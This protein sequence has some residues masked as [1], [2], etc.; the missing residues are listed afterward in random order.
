[1]N[2]YRTM[3]NTL[4]MSREQFAKVIGVSPDT[5]RDW[6]YGRHEPNRYAQSR[7]RIVADKNNIRW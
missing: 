7:L 3:R 4:G 5:V 2:E 1:M 6:E